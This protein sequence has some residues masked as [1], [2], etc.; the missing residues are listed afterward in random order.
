M[1]Q[2]VQWFQMAWSGELWDTAGI[3]SHGTQKQK[4]ELVK[5]V[6][7]RKQTDGG[8]VEGGMVSLSRKSI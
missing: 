7:N 6:L 4:N 8:G 2:G 5:K 3:A 1:E